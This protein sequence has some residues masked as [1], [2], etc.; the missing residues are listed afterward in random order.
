MAGHG[1]RRPGAGRPPGAVSQVK[2]DLAKAAQEHTDAALL[3]LR[4]VMADASTPP[5]ARIAA[6][7][8]ILD[9]GHG[10]P[11]QAVEVA[12]H[13]GGPVQ[14]LDYSKLSDSA[15]RELMAL[16]DAEARNA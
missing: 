3:V 15:L 14:T 2:R 13:G 5:S 16:Y 10:K 6:A 12:G 11:R 4:E 7:V 9:R 8:A 1:G